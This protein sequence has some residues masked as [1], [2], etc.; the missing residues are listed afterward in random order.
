MRNLKSAV[1][2]ITVAAA[3][4]VANPAAAAPKAGREPRSFFTTLKNY[5]VHILDD[6][7]LILP[8]G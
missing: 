6:S 1:F 4:V 7:K 8:P 2:A 3:I 5:I